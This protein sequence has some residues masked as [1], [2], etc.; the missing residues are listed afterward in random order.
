M[1]G[2]PVPRALFYVAFLFL[3]CLASTFPFWVAANVVRAEYRRLLHAVTCA[4]RVFFYSICLFCILVALK[5]LHLAPRDPRSELFGWIHLGGTL[6]ICFPSAWRAFHLKG[7]R[8]A[9]LVLLAWL[10]AGL[11]GWGA[12]LAS[13]GFRALVVEMPRSLATP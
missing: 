9:A 3:L 12:A 7:P 6:W 10:Q 1:P 8:L 5:S 11:L 2:E 4:M 13:P